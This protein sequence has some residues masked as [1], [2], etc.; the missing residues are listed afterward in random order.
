MHGRTKLR[1]AGGKGRSMGP[2]DIEESMML[3]A[4]ELLTIRLGLKGVVLHVCKKEETEEEE[5]G[6]E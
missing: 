5:R 4:M 2:K 3:F 6:I 1:G